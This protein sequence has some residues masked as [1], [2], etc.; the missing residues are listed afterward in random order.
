MA[1]KRNDRKVIRR[2]EAEKRAQRPIV[3]NKRCGHRHSSEGARNCPV[4]TKVD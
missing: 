1:N 2:V 4:L 3:Q